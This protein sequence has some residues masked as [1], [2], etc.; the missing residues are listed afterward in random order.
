[1]QSVSKHLCYN[2]SFYNE[3]LSFWNDK[4]NHFYQL[5]FWIYTPSRHKFQALNSLQKKC[6][7]SDFI[8]RHYVKMPLIK[9]WKR[10]TKF[11]ISISLSE[12][13][14]CQNLIMSIKVINMTG[15]SSK[16]NKLRNINTIGCQV[17]NITIQ[18]WKIHNIKIIS[19]IINFSLNKTI[20]CR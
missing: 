8:F 20:R 15:H 17:R 6:F 3:Q 18:K 4:E 5:F 14:G 7:Q 16:S 11:M 2:Q 1:M 9:F 10:L 13:F 19:F 12:K